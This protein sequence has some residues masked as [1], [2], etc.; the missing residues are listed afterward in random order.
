AR[1]STS[2]HPMPLAA[3]RSPAAP[4]ASAATAPAHC[5]I[6]YGFDTSAGGSDVLASAAM[7]YTAAL[8]F[9]VGCQSSGRAPLANADLSFGST[10]MARKVMTADGGDA[11]F[12][13]ASACVTATEAAQ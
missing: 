8:V 9:L 1:T 10:D 12:D 4:T 13:P 6:N 3:C 2:A 7:K 11:P 5:K